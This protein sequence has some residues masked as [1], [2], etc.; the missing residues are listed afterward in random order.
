MLTRGARE[1][2][3]RYWSPT[4]QEAWRANVADGKRGL[5]R[6]RPLFTALYSKARQGQGDRVEGTQL[7]T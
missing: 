1:T 4:R 5:V 7:L 3:G 6:L 2:F